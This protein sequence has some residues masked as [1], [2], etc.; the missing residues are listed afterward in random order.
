MLVSHLISRSLQQNGEVRCYDVAVD[1]IASPSFKKKWRSVLCWTI[2]L[3]WCKGRSVWIS[4]L[5]GDFHNRSPWMLHT[6][7]EYERS[8][9]CPDPN[10]LQVSVH[11][12]PAKCKVLQWR[13][14]SIHS[15]QTER[16]ERVVKPPYAIVSWASWLCRTSSWTS[17][18]KE[19]EERSLTSAPT[20]V[21]LL[22]SIHP[23]RWESS[24]NLRFPK[25]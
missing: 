7:S 25:K 5:I 8:R 20:G 13:L 1:F 15:T 21:K 18:V 12:E 6:L 9:P 3:T 14:L 19:R 16:I 24:W 11:P 22:L 17:E 4:T 10:S 23:K 2:T